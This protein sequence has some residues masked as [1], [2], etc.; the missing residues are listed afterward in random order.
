MN[1]ESLLRSVRTTTFLIQKPETDI[2]NYWDLPI[3]GLHHEHIKSAVTEL[4]KSRQKAGEKISNPSLKVKDLLD[5]IATS[6][7]ANSYDHWLHHVEPQLEEFLRDNNLREPADLIKWERPPSAW[8][9]S[10]RQIADRFFYSNRPLPKRIFTGVG[11]LMFAAYAYGGYD[12]D[13]IGTR[14]TEGR[15]FRHRSDFEKMD[16]AFSHKDQIVLRATELKGRDSENLIYLDLT[17]QTL[18]L[19]AFKRDVSCVFNLLGD[20]LIQPAL[21][22]N[23]F[24][25]YHTDEADLER[26]GRISEIF[27]DAIEHSEVGWVDVIP[28]NNNII[29]LRD[30]VGRFDWV[31]RD[32]RDCSFS[33]NDLYPIFRAD[34]LP[35]AVGRKAIQ[36]HLHYSK[37]LWIEQLRHLSEHHHYDSGGTVATYPG[38]DEIVER[39][40]IATSG[41]KP[42]KQITSD[43]HIDFIPHVLQEKCL[44]V[45]DLISTDEYLQFYESEWQDIRTIKSELSDRKWTSIPEMN[46]NDQGFLPASVTWFDAI[47]YCKFVE[48][49]TNL[50]VRLLTIDEWQAISPSRKMVDDRGLEAKANVVEAFN[51]AGKLLRPPTYLPHYITR[52]KS[53]LCWIKNI[54]GLNFLSSLTFGEWLG[55][56][57]GSAP[58]NV[59]APVACTASGIALGRGPLETE[60]FE[61]W[62]VGKNNH[63]KVGFRICYVADLNS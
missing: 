29:F 46:P 50:P 44:M 59:R 11:N 4:R 2:P 27:R 8:S 15:N 38:E 37:G 23:E 22:A 21:G 51:E 40:L 9:L 43:Q 24:Q 28:F 3:A 13:Q 19:N 7:G 34:E 36:A 54:Q 56:Y 12:L 30:V 57:R 25:L 1:F 16:F 41:Y 53:N 10:S 31:V 47:A 32:Q 63:L 39:F 52:F 18:V 49:R 6:L 17:A 35:K 60:L 5:N 20:S 58:N 33:S 62:Y 14:L 26:M 45:S 61:A 42:S 48:R 55:D